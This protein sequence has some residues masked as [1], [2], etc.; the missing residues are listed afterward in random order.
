MNAEEIVRCEPVLTAEEMKRCDSDTITRLG[1]P[2]LVL[3]ERAA[4]A[5]VS[6]FYER[7]L[8]L[9]RVLVLCGTGNNGGDG[10]AVARILAERGVK[11]V[12]AMPGDRKKCSQETEA[13]LAIAAQYG[14]AVSKEI[15]PGDYSLA[16]DALFGIGLSREITGVYREA[17]ERFN[18]LRAVKAAIDIPSGVDT[19]TG[20]IHGIA[21]QADITVTFAFRKRGLLLYPGAACAGEVICR[22]IG[23][24]ARSFVGWQPALYSCPAGKRGGLPLPERRAD[25]NKGT[26]GKVCLAAGSR[27]VGGAAYLSA[28]AAFRGGAGMVRLITHEANRSF[29]LQKLPEA[30]LLSYGRDSSGLSGEALA[31]ALTW[32]DVLAAGPGMGLG[33]EAEMLLSGMLAREKPLV[34]DADAI[35][36]LAEKE[37]LGKAL[38][39]RSAPA[40]LTPH[41]GEMSRLT[42]MEVV[43]IK[44]ALVETAQEWAAR[45]NAVLVLKDARTIVAS[46]DGRAYI[47]Q[48]GNSGMATAGSGD[49]LTGLVCAMLAQGMTAFDGAAA[50]VFLHG[51]AGDAAAL[52]LGEYAVMATDIIDG[53]AAV[54]KLGG[55]RHAETV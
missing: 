31:D 11:A 52:K 30:M 37:T 41:L 15:P 23:I 35:S 49:V 24:T 7:K 19:D 29:L 4:L 55:E 53:L 38:T 2:S 28:C 8:P 44:A 16:V 25:G 42:G 21:V 27:D 22:D 3:M 45:L 9:T 39:A 13:Q 1:V 12:L 10:V 34:L 54:G 20:C 48:S 33:E 18:A 51:L 14:L 50:A 6:V 43:A 26:F 46:P 17:V 5:A 40:V 36:L 32:A 47:N